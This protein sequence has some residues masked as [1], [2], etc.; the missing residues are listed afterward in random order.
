M[1]IYAYSHRD[2]R[3][4]F[5]P[6]D[7]L[8]TLGEPRHVRQGRLYVFAP[9]A[10]AAWRRLNTMD[11]APRS[12]R[13]LRRSEDRGTVSA[14]IAAHLDHDGAVYARPMTGF[15]VV[16]VRQ[17]TSDRFLDRIGEIREGKFIPS[18]VNHEH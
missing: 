3:A 5:L 9:T 7:I 11:L 6:R 16:W 1:K 13:G 17:H 4:C 2:P 14:L 15:G 12:V 10:D 18:E 8:D